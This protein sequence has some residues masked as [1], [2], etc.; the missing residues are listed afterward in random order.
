MVDISPNKTHAILAGK[1]VLKTVRVD[2]TNIS[3]GLNLRSNIV[4]CTG[5]RGSGSSVQLDIHDVKWSSGPNDSYVATA[6]SNGRINVYD[7]NRAGSA[8]AQVARLHEH[9]RQVHRLAFN[10]HQGNLLLSGSQDSTVKLWDLRTKPKSVLSCSSRRTFLGQSDSIRDLRWSPTDGVEFAFGTDSGVIQRWDFNAP[11]IHKLKIMAHNNKTCHAIDW[12]PD[13]KHLMSAGSDRTIKVWNFAETTSRQNASWIIK[14]P[15]KV[16]DARWRPV[17][18]MGEGKSSG[19]LQS[20][21]IAT[22]YRGHHMAHVWDFRR[23]FLPYRE[24]RQYNA[25]P[26]CILWKNEG[27]LWSVTGGGDGSFIQTDVQYAQKVL[28]QRNLQ[29]FAL[30]PDGEISCMLQKRVK[31]RASSFRFRTDEQQKSKKISPEKLAS[32]SSVDDTIPEESLLS[33]SF[34]KR[35][36]RSSSNRSVK[37]L[38]STPP[39]EDGLRKLALNDS[40]RRSS[41]AHA[42][43]QLA[44]RGKLPGAVKSCFFTFLAQKYKKPLPSEV[45]KLDGPTAIEGLFFR[46]A[47]YAQ[48]AA[49]YRLA[50]SWKILGLAISKVVYQRRQ[51]KLLERSEENTSAK[52]DAD[53]STTNEKKRLNGS[54]A[55]TKNVPKTAIPPIYIESTSNMTTP[56]AKPVANAISQAQPD[57]SSKTPSEPDDNLTLPPSSYP[58]SSS[59]KQDDA[60]TDVENTREGLDVDYANPK[61][62][63]T[64]TDLDERR[65]KYGSWQAQPKVPL[66]LDPKGEYA[67]NLST[68]GQLER[69][70]SMDSFQMFSASSDSQGADSVPDSFK[71]GHS[72][73]QSRS[74]VDRWMLERL[75]QGS[76]HS[77]ELS[78]RGKAAARDGSPEDGR[79][80]AH[81]TDSN[82]IVASVPNLNPFPGTSLQSSN[83]KSPYTSFDSDT[84]YGDSIGLEHS[85]RAA[86]STH[87][88]KTGHVGHSAEMLKS[89][90]IISQDHGA[91]LARSRSMNQNGAKA[92]D[93][94]SEA[95]DSKNKEYDS[96]LP[97]TMIDM[98]RKVI[99]YHLINLS[100]V[101]TLSHFLLLLIPLLPPT[102][103]LPEEEVSAILKIYAEYL[104]GTGMAPDEIAAILTNDLSPVTQVGLS[105]LQMEAVLTTYHEQVVSLNLYNVA[106]QLRQMSYPA[107]PGVYEQS[108][109]D[110]CVGLLCQ[111]CNKPIHNARNKFRCENCRAR[112][113]SCPICWSITSPY[114]EYSKKKLAPDEKLFRS[115]LTSPTAETKF[116]YLPSISAQS[117]VQHDKTKLDGGPSSPKPF[118][119]HRQN[120][121]RENAET[122]A[123][124]NVSDKNLPTQ[125]TAIEPPKVPNNAKSSFSSSSS[126]SS[127]VS[128]PITPPNCLWSWCALCGHGGHMSCLLIWFSELLSGSGACPIEGCPCDCVRGS[129]RE[130][131]RM[132]SATA[133]STASAGSASVTTMTPIGMM[134]QHGSNSN[135]NSN[136]SRGGK[137]GAGRGTSRSG[138]YLYRDNKSGGGGIIG[139]NNNSNNNNNKKSG[140]I[141]DGG[142]RGQGSADPMGG[143]GGSAKIA[144]GGLGGVNGAGGAGGAGNSGIH[145]G[146]G[147]GSG[148]SHDGVAAAGVSNGDADGAAALGRSTANGGRGTVGG[149]A[150]AGAGAGGAGSGGR[151]VGFVE[152]NYA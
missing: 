119:W 19:M 27:L 43:G 148:G 136:V 120:G 64:K 142:H 6:V 132:A 28:D 109:K 83:Q 31:R 82:G 134:M 55:P 60:R 141:A 21:Q 78:S 115:T 81:D 16:L 80:T 38:A 131:R 144:S 5:S 88:S 112:Q 75:Q 76:L 105:P 103:P 70:D 17:R 98:L 4:N 96:G 124:S 36:G 11:K 123:K 47:E 137:T 145:V 57:K 121:E 18:L 72:D 94:S 1:E 34:R 77:R 91:A 20:T 35:H 104:S 102:H 92:V 101:Q 25:Q 23:R 33:S 100:D 61:M 152:P 138:R 85:D 65:A 127:S 10:P 45:A 86:N 56:L 84:S 129:T 73:S 3:D 97:F 150:A 15:F 52:A 58:V 42:V 146:A 7:L 40:M 74:G 26:T 37:S 87:I 95:A 151:R 147:S 135:S 113:A 106:T 89:E 54:T 111:S 8:T 128:P 49:C 22:F 32:R 90:G 93:W 110:V 116:S 140:G 14:T 2:G 125:P 39:S 126:T 118:S 107:Y 149:S 108:V 62:Y 130:E 24:I 117:N 122:S 133:A 99:D 143:K 12:H 139:R 50:Q 13:G 71:S 9:E 67:A 79:S 51:M 48:I 44:F 114:L 63:N 46:N 59:A 53:T 30:S 41:D 29:T 69:Y 68:S 66:S